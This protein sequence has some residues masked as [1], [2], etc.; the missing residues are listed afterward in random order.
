M[1]TK[2]PWIRNRRTALYLGYGGLILGALAM[3]DAYENR[4]HRRPLLTK[5]LPA[6]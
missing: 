4:G 1:A 6:S 5:F 2:K 3:Y